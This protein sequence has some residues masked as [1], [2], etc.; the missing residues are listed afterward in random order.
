MSHYCLKNQPLGTFLNKYRY[1]ID[2]E[3]I[4]KMNLILFLKQPEILSHLSRWDTLPKLKQS[5]CPV[6]L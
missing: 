6:L 2:E 1:N 3:H 5:G 4:G